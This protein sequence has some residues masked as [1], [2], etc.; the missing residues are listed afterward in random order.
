MQQQQQQQ[1]QGVQKRLFKY[2][3]FELVAIHRQVKALAS[4]VDTPLTAAEHDSLSIKLQQEL[5]KMRGNILHALAEI[6]GKQQLDAI[7]FL[8]S[9]TYELSMFTELNEYEH[10]PSEWAIDND[11]FALAHWLDLKHAELLEA[12]FDEQEGC[13]HETLDF[14]QVVDEHVQL[15]VDYETSKK[16][17]REPEQEKESQPVKRVK[18][19]T[20]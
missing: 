4:Y 20:E 16:R 7:R 6:D 5:S 3:M 13:A 12:A 14:Y 1:Q 8:R 19:E 9:Q 15:S 10:T 11:N 17:Q 2:E 18:A